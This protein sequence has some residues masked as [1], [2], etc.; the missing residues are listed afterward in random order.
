MEEIFAHPSLASKQYRCH[1]SGGPPQQV[2]L[3]TTLVSERERGVWRRYRLAP[4]PTSAL[5][6]ATVVGSLAI[7][8]SP[9]SA[10]GRCVNV[11]IASSP[12]K[13]TLLTE[14]P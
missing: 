3:A 14:H 12:E 13:L 1:L 2:G 11:D 6:V 8:G 4:V 9:A 7:S 5:V 10:G